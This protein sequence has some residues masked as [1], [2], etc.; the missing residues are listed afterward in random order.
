MLSLLPV[1]AFTTLPQAPRSQAAE[2][3]RDEPREFLYYDYLED[4]V[5][6]GGRIP[7]DPENPLHADSGVLRLGAASPVTT[8]VS[9]GPPSNR[10]DLTFVGDGYTAAELGVYASDVDSIW[11]VFLAEPP[12]AEYAT[13]FN[14]HRVDVTS[15]ESGVDNDP[16]Q[17]ILRSTALDMG[18]WCSG[19]QRLLCVNVSKANA[20]ANS[21]PGKDSVLALA[22]SGTYG[23]AG[24]TNLGTVAGHNGAAIEIALHEFGH[25]FASL[26]D[27]YDYGG[28]ANYP[29]P[30]PSEQNITIYPEAQH[31]AQ[32]KK[33][34]R[35]LDLPNV[36]TFQGAD[37][38]RF[39]IYRPTFDSKMRSLG[40]PF[41]EVNA[42]RLVRNV[43]RFVRPI[44]AATPEGA[45][46][47]D[48]DFFVDPVDPVSH[49]LDVQ[50]RID[51]KKIPGATGTSFDA[52]S[53]GLAVGSYVLS[54]EVV[55]NTPLVR[56]PS[57]RTGYMSEGRTWFLTDGKKVRP[58]G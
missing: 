41:E 44:D 14:V 25:S 43:Y 46:A 18:Y 47:L 31:L 34:W 24:Y 11:P 1:L 20:Q 12:L 30:E 8:L 19:I 39:G 16:S 28:P 10:V 27:E 55:D 17:G 57:I 7:V 36:S 40:R 6:R 33:W 52:G 15:P 50:W 51:G 3:G 9:N 32:K 5:L 23:G 38:S 56:T 54:V 21:A 13:L 4:G 26:A 2:L 45:Y 58:R 22:N 48:A 29:D 35:W 42:E 37:Y 53:L 49:A